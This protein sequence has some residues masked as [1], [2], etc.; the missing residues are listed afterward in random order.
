M[1]IFIHAAWLIAQPEHSG[2]INDFINYAMSHDNVYLATITQVG[3]RAGIHPGGLA[4][5]PRRAMPP[6]HVVSQTLIV[7]MHDRQYVLP[8]FH[9]A[10][11]YSHDDAPL[12]QQS[13]RFMHMHALLQQPGLKHAISIN[14]THPSAL[15]H[16]QVIDWIKNPVKASQYSHPCNDQSPT[17]CLMP[18]GGCASVSISRTTPA[19]RHWDLLFGS[20]ACPL[21]W[22]DERLVVGC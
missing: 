13:G 10:C 5:E 3:G 8:L 19:S 16:V 9:L 22:P 15:P 14:P 20:L 18:E 7:S 1:G 17:E 6:L 11:H 12:R 4:W 21:S 2:Q